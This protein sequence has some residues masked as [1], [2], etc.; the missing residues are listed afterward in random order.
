MFSTLFL[1]SVCIYSTFWSPSRRGVAMGLM[2]GALTL[3]TASPN[4]LSLASSESCSS[5]ST[6]WELSRSLVS[7]CGLEGSFLSYL[8]LYK[9]PYPFPKTAKFECSQVEILSDTYPSHWLTY[10][11]SFYSHA[12]QML[13]VFFAI[14]DLGACS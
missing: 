8:F 12:F 1:S 11:R 5:A 9:G 4:L 7:V 13:L 14:L 10:L 2:I 3:G 6:N